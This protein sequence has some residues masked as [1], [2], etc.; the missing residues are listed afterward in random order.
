[1]ETFH[2]SALC[3][4]TTG[5]D[6]ALDEIEPHL[7]TESEAMRADEQDELDEDGSAEAQVICPYI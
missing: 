5:V 2:G 1:M 4:L 7:Y 6:V 3:K